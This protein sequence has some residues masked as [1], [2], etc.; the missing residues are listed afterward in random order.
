MLRVG[1]L[2]LTPVSF[3]RR[4]ITWADVSFNV[5]I[6]IVLDK[7]KVFTTSCTYLEDAGEA[8]AGVSVFFKR[9]MCSILCPAHQSPTQDVV[10]MLFVEEINVSEISRS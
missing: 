5:G 7:G 8:S 9:K 2:K 6:K 4:L 10:V 1:D 3:A